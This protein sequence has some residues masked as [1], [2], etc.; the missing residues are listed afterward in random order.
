MSKE[1]KYLIQTLLNTG[2]VD[3]LRFHRLSIRSRVPYYYNAS[4][5]ITAEIE[6]KKK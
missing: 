4:G 3:I 1:Q 2:N 6:R 5:K